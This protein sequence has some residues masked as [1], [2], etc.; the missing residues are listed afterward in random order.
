MHS[1]IESDPLWDFPSLA[2]D[3]YWLELEGERSAKDL[4]RYLEALSPSDVRMQSVL[5]VAARRQLRSFMS[6]FV[7]LMLDED[8]SVDVRYAAAD[9]FASVIRG[10]DV[11]NGAVLD[12]IEKLWC[13]DIAYLRVEGLIAQSVV[14]MPRALEWAQGILENPNAHEQEI[15]QAK[16]FLAGG[17]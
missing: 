2:S 13:S 12:A 14:D 15:H 10:K 5:H 3:D 7:E 17:K 1:K 4:R 6:K 11:S 16:Y 8:L 9:S